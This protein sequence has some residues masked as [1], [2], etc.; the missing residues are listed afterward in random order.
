MQLS[1]TPLLLAIELGFLFALAWRCRQIDGARGPTAPVFLYLAWITAYAIVSGVLGARGAYVD[2]RLLAWWPGLW[3][4][5]VTVAACVGPVVLLARVRQ[6]LR[7]IVDVTPLH[8]FAGFQ[9]LRIAALGT[10]TKPWSGSSRP[11]SRSSWAY[12]ICCSGSPPCGSRTG[13][14]A[15]R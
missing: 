1:L 10:P 8:W 15:A 5:L 13:C 14:D 11:R 7:Q 4:Q 12:R 9:V 2:D 3:L 6:G